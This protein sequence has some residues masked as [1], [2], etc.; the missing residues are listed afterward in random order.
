MLF[1]RYLVRIYKSF[2]SILILSI[3]LGKE[4]ILWHQSDRGPIFTRNLFF[5]SHVC[6]FM[7]FHKG[8]RIKRLDNI[9]YASFPFS[10]VNCIYYPIIKKPHTVSPASQIK[11]RKDLVT[12]PK[13][14]FQLKMHKKLQENK[15]D[16]KFR[17]NP[18]T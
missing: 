18:E 13:A 5:Q 15:N 1:F 9:L 11:M 3:T 4:N 6:H 7:H 14:G 2:S 10:S 12:N 17:K 8:L 16:L